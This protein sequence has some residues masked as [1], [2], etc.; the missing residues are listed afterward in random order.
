[1]YTVNSSDVPVTPGKIMMNVWPGTGVDSWLQPYNGVTP[2]TGYYDWAVY[3][4]PGSG[5]QTT[6]QS[7]TEATTT[8]AAAQDGYVV[9]GPEWNNLDYWSVYFASGW[10]NNPTGSYKA[11]SSYNDFSV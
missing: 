8:T 10:A 7:V 3:D 11:G 2:L 9:A 5:E 1:M 6:T 4:A